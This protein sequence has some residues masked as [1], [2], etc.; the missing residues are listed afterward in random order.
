MASCGSQ[1]VGV[2]TTGGAGVVNHGSAAAAGRIARAS[3][4]ESHVVCAGTGPAVT[5]HVVVVSAIPWWAAG[6]CLDSQRR[7]PLSEPPAAKMTVEQ[8]TA[9]I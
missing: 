1:M 9:V 8:L 2:V 6:P 7:G 5:R 4:W 3:E